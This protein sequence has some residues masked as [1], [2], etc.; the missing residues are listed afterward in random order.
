MDIDQYD[1]VLGGIAASLITGVSLGAL[2]SVPI[3]YGAGAGAA[4]SMSFMYYGMF[5]NAPLQN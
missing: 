3:Y 1:K 2:T 4:L 5:E